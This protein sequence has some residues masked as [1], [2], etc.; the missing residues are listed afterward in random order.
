MKINPILITDGYKT[1]HHRMY[2]EGTSLVYS[3][4]TLRNTDYMPKDA[5][6]IVVF[7]I[8]YVTR[9]SQGGAIKS[10]YC[11]ITNKDGS[12]IHRNIYKDPKTDIDK[13]KKIISWKSKSI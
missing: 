2:P 12:V 5:K 8:Q 4:Y 11:E 7:G 1:S 10:T 9:D 3:N 6:D 13:T